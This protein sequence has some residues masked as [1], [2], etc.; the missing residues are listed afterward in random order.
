MTVPELS[1]YYDLIV[2]EIVVS[3]DSDWNVHIL[4]DQN[5]VPERPRTGVDQWISGRHPP[6]LQSHQNC[7][8]DPHT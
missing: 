6:G 8:G 7:E 5:R 1:T 2:T 4:Q 3:C